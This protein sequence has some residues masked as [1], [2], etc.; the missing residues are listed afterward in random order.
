MGSGDRKSS[1]ADGSQSGCFDN[2][3]SGQLGLPLIRNGS[4]EKQLAGG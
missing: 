4:V 2:V 1:S 3:G